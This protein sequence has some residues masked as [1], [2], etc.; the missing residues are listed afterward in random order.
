MEAHTARVIGAV[1]VG[2]GQADDTLHV[3]GAIRQSKTRDRALSPETQRKRINAWTDDND[4]KVVKFTVDLS[5][6]GGKSAFRR[7]GLGP[8]LTEP[9]KIKTWDV[10]VVTRLDRACRD[11]ADYLKLSAWC[12]RN[13]KRFVVLDD[14][15][16]DTSTPGGRAMGAMRAT[17]AQYEREMAAERNRDNRQEQIE[18]GHWPGGRLPY[19][20]RYNRDARHLVPDDG[21]TAD[22]LRTMA[23]MAIA[24]K[25]QGQIAEWL[26][27][28]NGSVCYLTMIRRQWKQDTVRRVLRHQNTAE[29]LGETKAARLRAALR[30]REQ[31]RGER[32]GGHMLL[33]V[34]YCR[35]CGSPLYCQVKRDRPSGG[36]YRCLKCMIHMRMDELEQQTENDLLFLYGDRELVELEPVPGDDHQVAIHALEREI[37]QLQSITG[38]EMVITAKQAE[39][40]HL[41]SLPFDPDHYV[42]VPQRITVAE[43]WDALDRAGKGSFLRSRHVRVFADRHTVEVHGGLFDESDEAPGYLEP[44]R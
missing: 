40:D 31:T 9:D 41:R 21:R 25:S 26:N 28:G 12:D 34:A 3:L 4:G 35:Q 1:A 10:L 15:T 13:G 29:L 44:M 39:I 23:D 27:G 22:V 37:E 7:K 33:R 5:T 14:P 32:V 24:G 11:V 2:E 17:F 43:H 18:Q 6:S 20:W 38:T 30:N 16:L 36:Y 19:G 42:P 8:W